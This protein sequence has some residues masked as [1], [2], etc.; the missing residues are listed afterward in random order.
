MR[1]PEQR[2]LTHPKFWNCPFGLYGPRVVRKE[3]ATPDF[4]IYNIS[5]DIEQV[6]KKLLRW[7]EILF[8]P[9]YLRIF[10]LYFFFLRSRVKD[11]AILIYLTGSLSLCKAYLC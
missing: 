8:L 2:Y 3:F 9:Q 11:L 6:I 7:T 10:H 4:K 5:V 1:I